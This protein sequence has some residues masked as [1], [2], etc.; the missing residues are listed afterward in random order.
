MAVEQLPPHPSIGLLPA[1]ELNKNTIL[2]QIIDNIKDYQELFPHV[3]LNILCNQCEDVKKKDVNQ[4]VFLAS[5]RC[6][7][8]ILIEFFLRCKLVNFYKRSRILQSS[9]RLLTPWTRT[10]KERSLHLE[11][12][13]LPLM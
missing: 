1:D 11:R 8:Q 7:R 3:D 2:D 9:K 5:V 4:E 12:V 13:P 10:R 6:S